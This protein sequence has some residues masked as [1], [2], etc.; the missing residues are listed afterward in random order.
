MRLA[1]Q[2]S[3]PVIGAMYVL[4]EPSIGLHPKDHKRILNAVKKIRDRGNTVIIVE[5]D[6]ESIRQ[7]DKVI[8]LGPGARKTRRPFNC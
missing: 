5:H 8:D 6:E 1:S 7:A 3:S 2:L 4:D